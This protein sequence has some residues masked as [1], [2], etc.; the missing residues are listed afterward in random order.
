[1]EFTPEKKEQV[2]WDKGLLYRLWIVKNQAETW[3]PCRQLIVPRKFRQQLLSMAHDLSCTTGH[4]GREW[5][6]QQLQ[7][8]FYWPRI[9]Q[10]VTDY[11]KSCE[12][13]QQKGKSGDKQR[14]PLQPLPIIDQHFQRVG[15]D[16]VGLLRH[17][18]HRGKKYILTLVD[19]ATQYPMA[20]ALT[21]T[22]APVVEDAPTKIFFQLG[23]PSEILTDRVGTSWLR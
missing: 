5:T 19:F 21:F 1:M 18:T 16:I 2:V 14:A 7:V 4:M 10:S 6:R 13:C 20:V 9:A 15:I 3:K 17:R 8:N 23:F 11:C 12:T 22:E